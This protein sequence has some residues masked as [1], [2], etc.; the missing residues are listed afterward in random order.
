MGSTWSAVVVI[1]YPVCCL[2]A[3][4]QGYERHVGSVT[5][6]GFLN[7]VH[8][9]TLATSNFARA[10][11]FAS[12]KGRLVVFESMNYQAGV[13]LPSDEPLHRQHQLG[14]AAAQMIPTVRIMRQVESRAWRAH[15][16]RLC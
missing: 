11:K 9:K 12:D 2:W 1:S 5:S 7:H 13:P 6:Y 15:S 10:Q 14:Y 4:F 3:L 16:N 8:F